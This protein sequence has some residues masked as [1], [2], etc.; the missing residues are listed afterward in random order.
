MNWYKVWKLIRRKIKNIN[1]KKN[2]KGK[3]EIKKGRGQLKG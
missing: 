2:K 1:N 3:I